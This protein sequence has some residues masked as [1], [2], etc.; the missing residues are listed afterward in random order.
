MEY[1]KIKFSLLSRGADQKETTIENGE[2]EFQVFEPQ[3]LS[4][5]IKASDNLVTVPIPDVDFNY[6][7]IRATYSENDSAVPAK[8]GD[9]APLTYRFNGSTD[10]V[11]CPKGIAIITTDISQLQI[12][13]SYDTNKILVEVYLG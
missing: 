8:Q 3:R 6:C 10:D 11:V 4:R 7:F 9:P 1:H 12:A 2:I 5:L 13:T